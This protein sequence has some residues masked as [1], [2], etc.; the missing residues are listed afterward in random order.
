MEHVAAIQEKPDGRLA[1]V[2][3]NGAAALLAVPEPSLGFGSAE[4][5][6]KLA[7]NPEFRA[8]YA[9]RDT[10]PPQVK[11]LQ[12]MR[13]QNRPFD[14]VPDG[15]FVHSITGQDLGER[16]RVLVLLSLQSRLLY[17]G[18]YDGSPR[19]ALCYSHDALS[20]HGAPGGSCRCCPLTKAS[21]DKDGKRRSAR[22][23]LTH[24]YV[25]L[26][27]AFRD[28]IADDGHLG[29]D[30][31]MG[32]ACLFSLQRGGLSSA[33]AWNGMLADRKNPGFTMVYDLAVTKRSGPG[34]AIY[35]PVARQVHRIFDPAA[36]A[37]LE[38][39]RHEAFL[40]REAILGYLTRSDSVAEP[41]PAVEVTQPEVR[42]AVAS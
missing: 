41:E 40:Q 12:K 22:C 38:E 30:L 14:E 13:N 27:V 24:S 28:G 42:A 18:E 34:G 26:P 33:Q 25:L 32:G 19:A 3:G 35:T 6:R 1:A 10:V 20:G 5:Y 29:P 4:A 21:Q 17:E 36:L 39:Y 16:L 31:A 23:T 37:A 15:H 8:S 2:A 9:A 7:D 11:L